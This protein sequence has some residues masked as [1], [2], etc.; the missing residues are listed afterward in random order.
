MASSSVSLYTSPTCGYCRQTKALLKELNVAYDD[1]DVTADPKNAEEA[2]HK[3][4]QFGVP[5]VLIGKHVIV[6]YD[7]AGIIAALKD[8]KI[9]PAAAA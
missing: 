6:G 5:V 4:N 7:K 1:H 2:V 8:E 3:S 9:L